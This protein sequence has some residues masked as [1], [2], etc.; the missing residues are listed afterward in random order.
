MAEIVRHG[1]GEDDESEPPGER[2]IAGLAEGFLDE[3]PSLF[4]WGWRVSFQHARQ[5][6]SL[7]TGLQ[8]AQPP[9]DQG[10]ETA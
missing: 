4:D 1:Q 7:A 2:Q 9:V 3:I 6:I 10:I 8:H 5:R